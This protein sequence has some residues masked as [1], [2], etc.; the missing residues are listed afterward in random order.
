MWQADAFRS[1]QRGKMLAADLR[2]G[3]DDP[4]RTEKE[5]AGRREGEGAGV[6]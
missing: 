2:K 5:G 4:M 6:H 1:W 3:G